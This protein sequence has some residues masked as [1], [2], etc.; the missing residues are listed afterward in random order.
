MFPDSVDFPASTAAQVRA[1]GGPS[2][3]RLRTTSRVQS[4]GA[5]LLGVRFSCHAGPIVKHWLHR[6]E[7]METATS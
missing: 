1:R 4:D 2:R 3:S 7:G 6:W 5:A